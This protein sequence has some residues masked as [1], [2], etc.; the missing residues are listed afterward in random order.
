MKFI[1]DNKYIEQ[2][3]VDEKEHP[4]LPLL[5]YN[6]TPVCQFSR[7]WDETTMQCRGLIV[8]KETK[9]IIARPFKKFFNYE[10]HA[11]KG[12][13]LPNEIPEVYAKLDGS[14]GILYFWE[15]VPYVATRGSFTSD[16]ALWATDYLRKS[17]LWQRL[18][19]DYT[20][21]F[22]IIY[23]ENRIV[24]NYDFS[25]LVHLAS[26]HTETGK[27]I[28]P[29]S[30]FPLV[31]TVPFSSYQDLKALNVKNEEGFVLHYPSADF[32]VKIKFEDYV[33]LHKVIT[34]LSQIGIWEMLRDGID[35]T[36]QD[37]PDEMYSWLDGVVTDLKTKFQ[38][39]ESSARETVEEAK[40]LE[41]RKDQAI[42]IQNKPY[43][44]VA[45]SMLDG[46]EYNS[47]I[48]KMI[49]PKGALSFRKDIDA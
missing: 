28:P 49:R 31:G 25:G 14:L 5:I 27:S 33:K 38:I 30:D 17:N 24:V 9:E 43:S 11:E 26:I 23:P 46:K 37:I 10:E 16:Q 20:H 39:I 35:P 41:T 4:E 18:D 42:F 44:G 8:H 13:E 34:G 29:D 36:T 19:Q 47:V 1:I 32:R 45:F 7:A 12:D 22:E 40:K 15:G 3:L 21:L 48:W 6:Y 2:K